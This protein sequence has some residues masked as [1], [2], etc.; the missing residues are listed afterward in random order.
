MTL[1]LSPEQEKQV[2]EAN[3]L[4]PFPRSGGLRGQDEWLTANRQCELERGDGVPEDELK[5][6]GERPGAAARRTRATIWL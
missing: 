1:Q 6:S 2:A 4:W 5:S 3:A